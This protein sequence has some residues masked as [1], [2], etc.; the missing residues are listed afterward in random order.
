LPALDHEVNGEM[1][2][3]LSRLYWMTGDEAYRNAARPIADTFLL[4]RLP[5]DEEALGLSDHACEILNGLAELFVIECRLGT[6]RAE[7]Y[8]GPMREMLERVIEVGAN[9]DGMLYWRINP[10]EGTV[11]DERLSDCWGYVYDAYYACYLATGDEWYREQV[12]RVLR[13]LPKYHDEEWFGGSDGLC[14][15]FESAIDLLNRV[16][17]EESTP[18]LDVTMERAWDLQQDDGTVE[19]WYGDGSFGRACIMYAHWKA[20]GCQLQPWRSDLAVGAQRQGDA[21]LLHLVADGPW[22][23]RLVFDKPRHQSIMGMPVNYPRINEL[24]E[25]FT[26]R[27]DERYAV[28]GLPTGAATWTGAQMATGVPVTLEAGAPVELVVRKQ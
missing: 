11:L 16:P 9:E 22:G 13:S 24:P 5:T 10:A 12:E 23:G 25:W 8:R 3:V 19:K 18:F 7:A 15:S 4:D 26:V 1:L 21:L 2:Q 17:V 20:Q 28:E 27:A 14:D 6:A